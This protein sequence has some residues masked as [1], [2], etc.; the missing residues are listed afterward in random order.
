LNAIKYTFSG[1]IILKLTQHKSLALK[2]N[3]LKSK[4]DQNIIQFSVEDTGKET[5]NF[6]EKLNF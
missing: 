5:N 3:N 1:S 2:S 6:K 4:K